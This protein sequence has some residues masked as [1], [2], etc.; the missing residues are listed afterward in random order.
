MPFEPSEQ[1]IGVLT[2]YLIPANAVLIFESVPTGVIE[3]DSVG[4]EYEVM[5]EQSIEVSLRTVNKQE[6]IAQI[7]GVNFGASFYR[8]HCVN[9]RLVSTIKNGD[10]AKCT[11]AD[12]A[13]GDTQTGEFVITALQQSAFK[14]ITTVLGTRFEGYFQQVGGT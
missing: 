12:A 8:G 4:N 14:A 9:P 11:I 3:L 7:P 10:R 6:S 13:T 2:P 5:G 1:I